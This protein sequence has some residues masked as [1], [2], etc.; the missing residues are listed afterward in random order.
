MFLFP[1]HKT[2]TTPNKSKQVL[3]RFVVQTLYNRAALIRDHWKV[4]CV[5]VLLGNHCNIERNKER[6]EERKEENGRRKE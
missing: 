1:N 3:T 6:M 2:F 5:T 4:V